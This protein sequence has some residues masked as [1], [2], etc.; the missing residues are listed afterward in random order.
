[1][2]C[3]STWAHWERKSDRLVT[4]YE[5]IDGRSEEALTCEWLTYFLLQW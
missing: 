1:M 3:L 5:A 4:H 2:K